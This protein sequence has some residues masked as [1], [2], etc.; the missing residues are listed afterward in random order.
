MTLPLGDS[1]LDAQGNIISSPTAGAAAVPPIVLCGGERPGAEAAA[2]AEAAAAAAAGAPAAVVTAAANRGLAAAGLPTVG[3]ATAA[4]AAAA[5]AGAGADTGAQA[6]ADGNCDND[7]NPYGCY[8]TRV[9]F[10]NSKGG[11]GGEAANGA[12]YPE[13]AWLELSPALQVELAAVVV[14]RSRSDDEPEQS[15][16]VELYVAQVEDA[17]G[18]LFAILRHSAVFLLIRSLGITHPDL[19]YLVQHNLVHPLP[20]FVSPL[21]FANPPEFLVAN[22]GHAAAAAL[23][24]E[25]SHIRRLFANIPFSAFAS[26]TLRCLLSVSPHTREALET[27]ATKERQ[28]RRSES[29]TDIKRTLMHAFLIFS[30]LDF[31][32]HFRSHFCL[33]SNHPLWYFLFASRR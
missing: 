23:A 18:D 24:A 25:P 10:L 26:A 14:T 28:V 9:A 16:E 11:G 13:T 30:I 3:T 17:I 7:D 22:M 31:K 19:D 33:I 15:D 8:F 2:L 4:A 20:P 29:E 32:T 27:L 1:S 21:V 6:C 12:F 5:G